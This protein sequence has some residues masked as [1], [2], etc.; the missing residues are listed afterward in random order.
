MANIQGFMLLE[1]LN[2]IFHKH[3]CEQLISRQ[4]MK[5]LQI[6]QMYLEY[7]LSTNLLQGIKTK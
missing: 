5:S 4:M 6:L 1:P 3:G 2:L 7:L